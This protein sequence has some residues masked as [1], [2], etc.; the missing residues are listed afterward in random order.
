MSSISNSFIERMFEGGIPLFTAYLT[1]F[2][3]VTLTM[4]S[5]AIFASYRLLQWIGVVAW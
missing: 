3:F 5:F 4:L 2:Y 1:S